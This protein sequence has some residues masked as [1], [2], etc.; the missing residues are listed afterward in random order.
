MEA[1]ETI[2]TQADLPDLEIFDNLNTYKEEL[3]HF[4]KSFL[5]MD[6]IHNIA[7][8]ST[9]KKIKLI[10][11][12]RTENKK[13]EPIEKSNAKVEDQTDEKLFSEMFGNYIQHNLGNY[14]KR[15]DDL[16]LTGPS[17]EKPR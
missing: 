9:T 16:D 4:L 17:N 15:F 6:Q 14:D 11:A 12:N 2:P 5:H 7:R 3:E 13:T 8:A 10:K 1:K